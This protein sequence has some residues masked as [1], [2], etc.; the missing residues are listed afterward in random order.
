M[1][2]CNLEWRIAMGLIELLG[3]A[4]APEIRG[5]FLWRG[6]SPNVAQSKEADGARNRLRP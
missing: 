5:R 1:A 3:F 4:F 6:I 2:R